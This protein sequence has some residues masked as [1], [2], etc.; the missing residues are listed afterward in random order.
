MRRRRSIREFASGALTLAQVGQILWAA[1]GNTDP[2][3]LRTA[4]SA[5]ALYPLETYLVAGEV[6]GLGPGVYFCPP[7]GRVLCL[8]QSGEKRRALAA[9]ALEQTWITAAKIV[10]VLSAVYARTTARYGQRGER[11]VHMEA[12]HVAQNVCLMAAS[13]GLGT[14]VVG[15]FRDS[16]VKEIVGMAADH[17]PLCLLPVGPI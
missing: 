13:L 14:T 8:L 3:G 7:K 4:P 6:D 9:A 11:Y 16:Q 10:L 1:Q 15:A 17:S 5:G 12:G 2:R